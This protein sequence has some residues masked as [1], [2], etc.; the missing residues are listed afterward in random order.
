MLASVGVVALLVC[1]GVAARPLIGLALT[2]D[3]VASSPAPAAGSPATT[4][5][6]TPS[7]TPAAS[8]SP[9]PAPSATDCRGAADTRATAAA[10]KLPFLVCGIALINKD[11]RVSAGY[12]PDLAAVDVRSSGTPTVRLQPVAGK[13]L[14]RLFAGAKA[15]GVTLVVRSSYRPYATQAQWYATMSH[16]RT[17]PAGAS[18]HQS[19][20][21][22]DLAGLEGGRLVHGSLLASSTTGKWLVRHAA[23]YG[24]ILRYPTSQAKITGIAYEPWH[25]RYVGTRVATAV[26]ATKTQTLERYLREG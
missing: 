19:G 14:V 25:F 21:A 6:G 4:P 5:P 23:E 17:A 22:A 16:A 26:D 1:A 24:F 11:H 12:T 15:A 20:L 3:P 2:G 7:P 10:K 9:T 8:L 13:A 18:E